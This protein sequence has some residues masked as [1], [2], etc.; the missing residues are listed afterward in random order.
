MDIKELLGDL[1]T[2]KIAEKI[3]DKK[4]IVDDGNL[5]NKADYIPRKVYNE[6]KDK[7]QKQLEE[8]T[9]EVEALGGELKNVKGA[10]EKVQELQ[11]KMKEA[12]EKNKAELR[13][14]RVDAAVEIALIK[15]KAKHPD[16]LK[17]KV[18]TDN[19]V[20][21]PDGT[22]TGISE[23]IEALKTGDYKDQFGEIKVDGDPPKDKDKDNGEL[24]YEGRKAEE[25]TFTD[26]LVLKK[27][28][29]D[30]YQKMFPGG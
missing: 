19:L 29:A 7:W 10:S 24:L 9:K 23:Q 3:G 17:H 28:N 1:Y 21:L 18:A 20:E 26:R 30:K 22:F 25:L 15:A 14:A 5:V 16:L 12:D 11:D 8:R 27:T 2:D 13:A 6:D 4:L